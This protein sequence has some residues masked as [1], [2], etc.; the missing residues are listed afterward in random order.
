M[1][2][3]KSHK[4]LVM[5][6]QA[7]TS[8]DQLL[9]RNVGEDGFSCCNCFKIYPRLKRPPLRRSTAR[10]QPLTTIATTATLKRVIF[11]LG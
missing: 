4:R 6:A 8:L 5:M 11:C 7:S 10:T 3:F 1:M 2:M 9:E